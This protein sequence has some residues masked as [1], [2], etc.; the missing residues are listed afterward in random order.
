LKFVLTEVNDL[1]L[2]KEFVKATDYSLAYCLLE[3]IGSC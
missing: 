2:V 3:L 1:F